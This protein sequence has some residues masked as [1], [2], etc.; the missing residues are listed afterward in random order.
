MLSDHVILFLY[1][2]CIADDKMPVISRLTLLTLCLVIYFM[3]KFRAREDN[4]LYRY[5]SWNEFIHSMLAKGEVSIIGSLFQHDF[6]STCKC[7]EIFKMNS[8]Y[9]ILSLCNVRRIDCWQVEHIIVKPEMET[10]FI[11]LF[12]GAVVKGQKVGIIF[13]LFDW[14]FTVCWHTC[15]KSLI[16]LRLCDHII[17]ITK[18]CT[19]IKMPRIINYVI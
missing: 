11:R 7:F 6:R 18:I 1:V 16:L 12:P 10:A 13:I 14:I 15:A 3:I 4:M 9:V 2:R 17:I 19:L 5:V 8:L